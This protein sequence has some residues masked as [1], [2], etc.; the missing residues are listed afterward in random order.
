MRV[1]AEPRAVD[2]RSSHQ[3]ED[4]IG[5][6]SSEN[7]LSFPKTE[8]SVWTPGSLVEHDEDLFALD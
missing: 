3:F 1:I 7:G 8:Y 2:L 5:A 6:E 4:E